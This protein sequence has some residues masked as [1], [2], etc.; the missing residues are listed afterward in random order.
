VAGALSAVNIE[1][2]KAAAL[3][4]NAPAGVSTL[5]MLLVAEGNR[6][7]LLYNDDLIERVDLN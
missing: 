3:F 4:G 5:L 7:L 2:R 1:A 6:G